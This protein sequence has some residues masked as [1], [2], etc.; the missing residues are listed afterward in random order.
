MKLSKKGRY[1]IRALIDLAVYSRD[2]HVSLNS[3]AERNNISPQFL[4][5]VFA[6]LR[7]A[8]IV[9]SIK[10]PQGGYLLSSEPENITVASILEVLEGNYLVENEEIPKEGTSYASSLTMQ[11]LV[12]DTVNT[13]LNGI[14]QNLTLADLE[15]SYMKKVS[16]SQDMYYI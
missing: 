7:R 9:R 16:Q 5:Q 2:T 10:G 8:G 6:S 1:G 14:L 11:E 15:K 3:I 12:I 13:K 4:E